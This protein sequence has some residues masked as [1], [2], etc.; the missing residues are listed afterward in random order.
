VGR[1]SY[2]PVVRYNSFRRQA[3]TWTEAWWVLEKVEFHF[4]ELIPTRGV[5]RDQL[6]DFKPN[7]D[8]RLYNKRGTAKQWIEES[9]Q[10]V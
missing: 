3:A 5:R 8:A 10:E 7:G 6:S 4:G 2:K 9:K 1:P